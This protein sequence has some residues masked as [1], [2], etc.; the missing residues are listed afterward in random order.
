M[1]KVSNVDYIIVTGFKASIKAVE[2]MH[3]K[4]YV[5]L[6]KRYKI[7]EGTCAAALLNEIVSRTPFEDGET[8]YIPF[9]L[10]YG[11][12][13]K[14]S[15]KTLRK[16]IGRLIDLGAAH[17]RYWDD[18]E[19]DRREFLLEFRDK[20]LKKSEIDLRK[21][22]SKVIV[23][24]EKLSNVEFEELDKLFDE[25]IFIPG[26]G[27]VYCASEEEV[28]LLGDDIISKEDVRGLPLEIK[29]TKCLEIYRDLVRSTRHDEKIKQTREERRRVAMEYAEKFQT[30][31]HIKDV[32]MVGS[33]AIGDDKEG[34]DIDL[35]LCRD[36]CPSKER[37]LKDIPKTNITVDIF[38]YTLEEIE[39]L[40]QAGALITF[41]S[42][43]YNQWRKDFELKV[44]VK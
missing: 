44:D 27:S 34:S 15:K 41:T 29:M 37:C 16:N 40:R 9:S 18:I 19:K 14:W 1:L 39:E 12:F 5:E 7:K 4:K 13:K 3:K 20:I 36:Y 28:K 42:V 6:L 30:M 2:E 43:P 23:P 10:F 33:L 21:V 31:P 35:L 22:F 25:R 32:Y 11:K 24:T 26:L 8:E 17:L 38:C